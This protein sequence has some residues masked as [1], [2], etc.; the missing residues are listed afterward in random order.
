METVAVKDIPQNLLIGSNLKE[1][2]L[3][4]HNLKHTEAA[5]KNVLPSA[6]DVKSEKN[7]LN[8]LIGQNLK[9][10]SKNILLKMELKV[11]LRMTVEIKCLLV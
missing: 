6:E 3:G 7:H 2:L 4:E 9:I 1:Q 8:I 5:E 11:R 10:I